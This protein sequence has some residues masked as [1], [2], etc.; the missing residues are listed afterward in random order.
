MNNIDYELVSKYL[1]KYYG[2]YSQIWMDFCTV[3]NKIV[4]HKIR[5]NDYKMIRGQST[6]YGYKDFESITKK[7][8]CDE[9][10]YE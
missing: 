7:L 10:N 8:K 4:I 6:S 5:W 3:P 9:L 1:I 2:D